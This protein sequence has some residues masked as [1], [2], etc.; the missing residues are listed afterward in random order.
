M[1]DASIRRR[2]KARLRIRVALRNHA[3]KQVAYWVKRRDKAHNPSPGA[4]S[5]P[6]HAG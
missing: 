1:S 4:S 3:K 5:R 6:A 2:W